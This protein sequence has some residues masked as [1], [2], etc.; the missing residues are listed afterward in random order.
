MKLIT[1]SIEIK[2]RLTLVR[3]HSVFV[4]FVKIIIIGFLAET[5]ELNRKDN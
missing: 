2:G 3:Q 5:K 4:R 1:K